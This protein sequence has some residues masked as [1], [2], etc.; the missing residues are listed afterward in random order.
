[1]H[2]RPQQLF[3]L[4]YSGHVLEKEIIQHGEEMNSRRAAIRAS[5]QVSFFPSL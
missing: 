3:F 1:V 4:V 2:I 5:V